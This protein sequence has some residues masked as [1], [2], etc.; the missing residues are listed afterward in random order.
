VPLSSSQK[1]KFLDFL[2]LEALERGV[3][4]TEGQQLMEHFTWVF[5]QVMDRVAAPEAQTISDDF[6]A[7]VKVLKIKAQNVIKTDSAAKDAAADA[8]I[9]SLNNE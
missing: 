6:K 3:N 4:L 5:G 8:E 9:I 1:Q 2:A 7:R